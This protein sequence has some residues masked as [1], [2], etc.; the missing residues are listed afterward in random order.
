LPIISPAFRVALSIAV[1]RAACSPAAL[2]SNARNTW[3]ERLRGSSCSRICSSFGS[4][5]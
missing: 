3:T 5:S 2:S 1:M 4:N